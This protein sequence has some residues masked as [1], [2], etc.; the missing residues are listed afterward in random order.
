MGAYG[1]SDADFITRQFI[2]NEN[3]PTLI[4]ETYKNIRTHLLSAMK[5]R[6]FPCVVVTSQCKNEGKTT[7]A[8]N[9]A[10]TLSLLEKRV[11]LIDGDLRR[12]SLDGLFRLKSRFGLSSVLSG[13]CDVYRAI[14]QDVLRNFHVMPAGETPENPADLLGGTNMERLIRLLC[15][16]YD[17]ILID[18]P[19]LCVA[20][21][22]LL[23]GGYTAGTVLVVREN[24]TTHTDLKKAL[25]TLSLAK[26]NLIG[27]VKT[28]CAAVKDEISDYK[29]LL[30]AAEEDGEDWKEREE[31][32]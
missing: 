2:L 15:E 24:R 6:G 21:D 10:I 26:A 9:L 13:R 31:E 29:S 18:T 32:P 1:S 3:T 4:T 17:Y 5:E 22:A 25:L 19:P 27:A 7:T 8:A 23:F 20:N 30:R 12:P 16:F 11:L 14:S 28:Y